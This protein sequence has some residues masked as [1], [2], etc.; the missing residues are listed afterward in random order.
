MTI[1][2]PEKIPQS[3]QITHSSIYEVAVIINSGWIAGVLLYEQNGRL[4]SW[5]FKDGEDLW[6]FQLLDIPEQQNIDSKLLNQDLL[7]KPT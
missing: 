3:D 5:Q 4:V 1:G 6:K 2:I 7:K